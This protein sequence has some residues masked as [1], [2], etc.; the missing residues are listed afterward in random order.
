MVA[1]T[2][3]LDDANPPERGRVRLVDSETDEQR[4]QS[5]GVVRRSQTTSHFQRS[6][7]IPGELDVAGMNSEYRDGTLTVRIPKA[8]A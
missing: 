4:D 7:P 8:H 2:L 5:G 6:L 1:Q 3:A